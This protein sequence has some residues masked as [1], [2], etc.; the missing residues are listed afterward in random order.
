M[1]VQPLRQRH[2]YS[3]TDADDIDVVDGLQVVEVVTQFAERQRER[4]TTGNDHVANLRV[5][6]NV[7][8]H[9]LVVFADA[10]P[11]TARKSR[12]F[13][14]AVAAI[15]RAVRRGNHQHA[16]GVAVREA[17]YRGIL[18]FFERVFEF[19]ARFRFERRGYRLQ[20]DRIGRVRRI[21][22]RKVVGRN[23]ELIIAFQ[24]SQGFEF[25]GG[26]GNEIAKLTNGPDRVLGLP[27]PV[28][29]LVVRHILPCRIASHSTRRL[30]FLESAHDRKGRL[31]GERLARFGLAHKLLDLHGSTRP[32]LRSTATDNSAGK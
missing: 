1:I 26:K 12:A 2:G 18:F 14:G 22:Q 10:F 8:D 27:S 7:I 3:R 19:E 11:A 4:V 15:H 32:G 29:P 17:G 25:V 28:V 13:A 5:L 6:A 9:P 30:V 20:S 31:I 23:G 21:D 24:F 16:V